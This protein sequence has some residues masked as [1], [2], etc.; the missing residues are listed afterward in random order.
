[1]ESDL[2]GHMYGAKNNIANLRSMCQAH[3]K[4]KSFGFAHCY[5]PQALHVDII[6][7]EP[8]NQLFVK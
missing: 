5:E 3:S 7:S 4:L 2:N 1:M 8:A 6:L